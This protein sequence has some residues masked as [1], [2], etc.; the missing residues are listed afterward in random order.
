MLGAFALI[1][2]AMQSS[3]SAAS[4]S[5]MTLTP[6]HLEGV[7]EELR[8]GTYQVFE[9]RQTR[10]GRIL[11]LKVVMIPARQPHPERG[12]IFYLSGGP[13]E[14]GT[15]MVPYLVSWGENAEHDVVIV[16]ERGTDGDHRLDCRPLGSDENLENYL[17]PPFDPAAAR[18]CR[19]ELE[20]HYDLSQYTTAASVEDLD[21]IRQ[22]M[23]YDRINLESGSFG[24]Y[25]AQMY[26]RKYGVHVRS[27]YLLS[28][29]TLSNRVPL[30]MARTSQHALDALFDQC[31]DDAKCGVAYPQLHEDFSAMLAKVHEGPVLTWVR[32][33]VTDART[34]VHLSEFSF[35]D[36]VRVLLYSSETARQIPFLIEQAADGDFSPFAEVAMRSVRGIYSGARI[37]LNYSITCNEFVNRIRPEEIGPATDARFFGAWRVN[38]QIATCKE[39][40][41][42]L[43][44]SDYF[45]LFRS[46]VP[47]LI[48]SGDTDPVSPPEYGEELKSSTPNS[49]HLIVPGGGHTPEN[50][51]LRSIRAEF[52][53][54]AEPSK[55][56]TSCMNKLRP[57]AFK[58]PASN[59]R[60]HDGR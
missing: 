26:I 42:T 16:N 31:H 39:W 13:G 48:V 1:G 43:V 28:L 51:C 23:G 55:L 25:K 56:N 45:E 2:A 9:N 33:P 21:E 10:R 3:A 6:C 15:D 44:P 20:R 24:T 30:E 50:A 36:A 14:T 8:C 46:D 38:G 58:L 52:F 57:E 41:K 11:S 29:V 18:I 47:V 54:T 32:H 7:R 40:A 35:V 4:R 19:Q 53:R 49:I 17:K 5:E 37:G 60:V 12:P 27:A 22:A 34:Q 59:A